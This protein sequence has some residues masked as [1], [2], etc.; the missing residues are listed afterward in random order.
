MALR[1]GVIDPEVRSEGFMRYSTRKRGWPSASL[2]EMLSDFERTLLAAT[3]VGDWTDAPDVCPITVKLV[4]NAYRGWRPASHWLYHRR[5]RVR[6]HL[7][8]LVSE[9]LRQVAAA[10]TSSAVADFLKREEKKEKGGAERGETK[11]IAKEK[12]KALLKELGARRGAKE[13]EHSAAESNSSSSSLRGSSSDDDQEDSED[14]ECHVDKILTDSAAGLPLLP[15]EMW[16][17]ILSFC[18]RSFWEQGNIY[19]LVEYIQPYTPTI[20]N[21][22]AMVSVTDRA[23]KDVVVNPS[24]AT[25]AADQQQEDTQDPLEDVDM[26]KWKVAKLK[27]ELKE[28]GLAVGGKKTELVQRLTEAVAPG[29]KAGGGKSAPHGDEGEQDNEIQVQKILLEF[30]VKQANEAAAFDDESDGS[31]SDGDGGDSDEEGDGGAAAEDG[32]DAGAAEGGIRSEYEME[33]DDS[34]EETQDPLEDV[35]VSKWKVAELKAELKERGLAVGGKKTE[36]VQRLTEDVASGSKAEDGDGDD[37]EDSE[38]GGDT[39][40]IVMSIGGE[41]DMRAFRSADAMAAAEGVACD[42]DEACEMGYCEHCGWSEFG[43]QEVPK[44]REHVWVVSDW[45]SGCCIQIIRICATES[46]ANDTSKACE[47]DGGWGGIEVQGEHTISKLT[48]E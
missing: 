3:T 9:R 47:E 15:P 23:I 13:G 44:G 12:N 14:G 8:L 16:L 36:L 21:E 40:C 37:D 27:A 32:D 30:H 31:E 19:S 38:D 29:F 28:R 7:V 48:I 26:S 42:D 11:R 34:D 5:F 22:I 41:G 4:E 45:C 43:A 24:S 6:M 17:H 20:N 46:A 1:L 10:P 18:C 35:D 33:G 39:V 25:P 2:K